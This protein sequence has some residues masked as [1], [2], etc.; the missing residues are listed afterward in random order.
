MMSIRHVSHEHLLQLIMQNAPL[1][2]TVLTPDLRYVIVSRTSL[3]MTGVSNDGDIVGMHCYDLVGQYRDS[4]DRVGLER[5]CDACPSLRALATGETAE[6]VRKVREDFVSHTL[7]VP[8]TEATGEIVGVL[9]IVEDISEKV[10]DPLTGVHNYR[11]YDEMVMQ[12]SYRAARY[13]TPLSLLAMDLN[14]FKR[15][16]DRF[17]HLRGDQVLREVAQTLARSVRESDHLCRIG[18]DEFTVVAPHTTSQEAEALA[19][20]IEKAVAANFAE[21]DITVSIGCASYPKD[22]TDPSQLREIADRRL[23]ALKDAVRSGT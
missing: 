17:G 20:R 4:T 2:I 7:A 18:G 6:A 10:I 3:Q 9:E 14:H 22:T 13:D 11:F 19:R 12:E 8:L 5:A 1:G 23:Y 16:N 21:Y 15:V